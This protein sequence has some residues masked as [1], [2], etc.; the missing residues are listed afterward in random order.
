MASCT[1]LNYKKV[2]SITSLL[3]FGVI[4]GV[5]LSHYGL[6]F[7]NISVD[8]TLSVLDDP[9]LTKN[10]SSKQTSVYKVP[11][12]VHFIWFGENKEMK[13]LNYI[14]ILSAHRIQKPD[15]IFLHCNHLPVGHWWEKLWREV[16]IKIHHREPPSEIH[17]QRLLH[18]YH[19]GD[20]AKIEIL[21]EHGG[22]YLDYDVIVVS[23]MNELRRYDTTLGK[24][25]PP[26]FIAG[27]IVARANAPFLKLWYE[28][29][30]DNYRA[31]DWDYN[32]A[33]VPY[34]IYLKR[35]D[36]LHVE[37]YKLTTP[38][39]KDRHQLWYEVI[40]WRKL[41]CIHVM[42]HLNWTE[43]DPSNIKDLDS[44]FGEVVR[45]IYYGNSSRIK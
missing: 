38:D 32:C 18:M 19:K 4:F 36:L 6:L 1:N 27:I 41:Y 26:K 22:I 37:P 9:L 2:F 24:E 14:S 43:Y 40:D 8:V 20:I 15:A 33:R 39:W 10:G 11:N 5:L 3:A 21:M 34:Q 12:I 28:S 13:F 16:P 17:G 29:Y 44:T 25:K 45:Y 23:S 7:E 30:R 35:Q 31:F 42:Q